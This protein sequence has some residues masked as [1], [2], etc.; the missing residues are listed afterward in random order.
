MCYG[1]LVLCLSMLNYASA[2]ETDTPQETKSAEDIVA[3]PTGVYEA[4]W[5]KQRVDTLVEAVNLGEKTSEDAD[6]L[7]H[8][9][10]SILWM[11]RDQLITVLDF[12]HTP[13]D[14]LDTMPG[15]QRQPSDGE[16][17]EGGSSDNGVR[18]E[19]GQLLYPETVVALYNSV[20]TM[21]QARVRLLSVVSTELRLA[22][23][24]THRVGIHELTGE[25]DEFGT[26]LKLSHLKL[27][28]LSRQL[29]EYG[30][31]I[32]LAALGLLVQLVF[33]ILLF[34]WWRNWSRAGLP[35][36]QAALMDI[37]PRKHLALRLVRAIWYFDRIRAPIEWLLLGIAL[38]D[39]FDIR[40]FGISIFHEFGRIV[41]SWVLVAW[42]IVRWVNAVAD[43]GAKSVSEYVSTMRRRSTWLIAGWLVFTGLG[44]ELSDNYLGKAT[45]YEW[46]KLSFWL[47]LVPI[48][49]LLLTWW[50]SEIRSHLETVVIK[51]EWVQEML[52]NKQ[53]ALGYRQALLGVI[54][55][56][57]LSLRRKLI[58]VVSELQSGRRFLANYLYRETLRAQ[59]EKGDDAGKPVNETL[60]NLLLVNDEH[61]YDKYARAELRQVAEFVNTSDFG[62]SVISGERGSG[63]S[64]F[65]SRLENRC[66]KKFLSVEVPVG[67]GCAGCLSVLS[68][69]L[70]IT[71][72]PGSHDAIYQ[73]LK[74]V[75]ADVLVLE[76]FH[77]LAHPSMGGQEELEK[78][79]EFITKSPRNF[80]YILT[81]DKMAW[82]YLQRVRAR[83]LMPEQV[84]ELTSWT[85]EQIGGLIQLRTQAAKINPDF[86]NFFLPAGFDQSGFRTMEERQRFGFYRILWASSDG[87][88]EVALR[89][90]V[91]SLSVL[92]DEK[93]IVGTPLQPDTEL[94]EASG[95]TTLLVLRVIAQSGYSTP[96]LVEQCL[97]FSRERV[98]SIFM[99]M[100]W[101]G[102]IEC[103]DGYY[104][105]SWRWFRPV[106]RV[107]IRQ[108]LLGR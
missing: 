42:L 51:P 85:E 24:G 29:P 1:V 95:I 82:Q 90:Y 79:L 72:E 21:Y 20:E 5:W 81:V 67:Q 14:R 71:F 40:G 13:Q 77:R 93:I 108:N 30:K 52:E 28:N 12:A 106:T 2:Q 22:V 27:E 70:G 9:L 37:R 34:R 76:S 19:D 92:D 60:R 61:V 100:Q 16:N 46:M 97:E 31:Q 23:T 66:H 63:K 53:G 102:W 96:A 73:Q 103:I 99:V 89:L 98:D 74:Q 35:R 56:V 48:G 83:Q 26:R 75:D 87:N 107:L 7:Y 69:A 80:L 8:Q 50:K 101:R 59:D 44:L 78:M 18:T 47:L 15:A 36:M 39:I 11:R 25:I 4:Q 45:L 94:L 49:F 33:V 6:R 57:S 88:P 41:F 84:I 38:F 86:S 64:V 43:R 10:N 105:I 54:Y 32:P 55:L 91:K 3:E 104:R 58:T 17:G 62:V 68:D 65:L